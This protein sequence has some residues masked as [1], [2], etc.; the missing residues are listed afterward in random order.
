MIIDA[1]IHV[2][3]YK[4]HFSEAFAKSTSGAFGSEANLWTV[5]P[6]KLLRDMDEA[7]ISKAVILGIDIT[8]VDPGTKSP[9]DYI[10]NNYL[11]NY[12]DRFIAFSGVLPIDSTG[13]FSPE[14]LKQFERSITELGFKG[15]KA[16]PSYSHYPPNHRSIYPY[17]QKAVELKVPVLLHTGMTS[18]TYA[19]AEYGNP[20]YIDDVAL[21]FPNLKICIAHMDYPWSKQLFA[22]MRKCHNIYT[23]IAALCLRP[24]EL[25]WHLVLAKEYQLMD[26][27]MW[28]TDYPVCNPKNYVNWMQEGLNDVVKRCGWPTFSNQEMN[29][30]LYE[31]ACEFLGL[32]TK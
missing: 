27:V 12:P 11:K 14:S 6:Q 28:G 2:G 7:G 19:K 31:N 16:T 22:V 18:F 25:T 17:Y 23:D 8:N 21:D 9:D 26:R 13:R 30:M 20:A 24:M 32:K 1:H 29:Q 10:Y 5:E 4:K 3:E 15:M